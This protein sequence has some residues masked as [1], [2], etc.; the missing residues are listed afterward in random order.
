MSV[1]LAKWHDL[2][3][4]FGTNH[5]VWWTHHCSLSSGAVCV[6]AVCVCVW[7]VFFICQSLTHDKWTVV[8]RVSKKLSS[9]WWR[10]PGRF[11]KCSNKTSGCGRCGLGFGFCW[12][13]RMERVGRLIE[14]DLNRSFFRVTY[15]HTK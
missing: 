9:L 7:A 1:V 11:V 6:C 4:P 15:S 5:L 10:W 14:I 13:T 12:K 2:D 8:T 3:A